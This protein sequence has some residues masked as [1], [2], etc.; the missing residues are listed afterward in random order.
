ME[1]NSTFTKRSSAMLGLRMSSK[2]TMYFLATVLVVGT[3][4]PVAFGQSYPS[5]PV[6][7]VVPYGAG[8]IADVTM[9]LAAQKMGESLGKQFI[10]DNRPGAG[11]TVGLKA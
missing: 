10:I 3:L 6:K 11:G 7:I 2:V 1:Y 4:I 5:H 9:R 8:G